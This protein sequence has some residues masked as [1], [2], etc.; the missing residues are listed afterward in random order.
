[1]I[2]LRIALIRIF[3]IILGP[4]TLYPTCRIDKLLLPGKER[5]T[6]GADFYADILHRGTRFDHVSAVTDNFG[7]FVVRMCFFLHF[8]FPLPSASAT[9]AIRSFGVESGGVSG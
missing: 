2:P 9:R 1:M 7:G 6:A 8:A 5:V 3:V 4:E